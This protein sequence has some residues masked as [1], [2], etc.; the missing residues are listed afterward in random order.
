MHTG[1]PLFYRVSIERFGIDMQAVNRRHGLEM[2]FGG[3]N[4]GA[5]LAGVMGT[6]DDIA[7]PVMDKLTL[8]VCENC[9]MDSLCVAQL[10]ECEPV[11]IGKQESE[12]ISNDG[13][14]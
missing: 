7:K 10:A 14:A 9:A 5:A 13:I 12:P 6:D 4:G 1:L 2:F 11:P 3:G 8:F